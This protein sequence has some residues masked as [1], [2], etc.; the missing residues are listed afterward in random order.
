MKTCQKVNSLAVASLLA[1]TGI[2]PAADF[3][4]AGNSAALDLASAWTNGTAPGATDIAVWNSQ[5]SGANAVDVLGGNTSWAGIRILNPGATVQINPDGSTLT[6]GLAGIDLSHAAEDLVLSNNLALNQPQ[7]W[8]LASGRTLTLGG[9]VV[10]NAGGAIRF[11]LAD[12]TAN[13][14]VTN[15]PGALLLNGDIAF[16]TVN[17]TDFAAINGSGQIVAGNT[18]G[19][20]TANPS[21]NFNGTVAVVDF[22]TAA[23]AGL[24]LNKNSVL[25][26]IRINQ[27]NTL[28]PYWTINTGGKTLSINSL[29]ITTNVGAQPV[30]VN[31]NGPVRIYNTGSDELLL[32]QNNP[33][34]PLV[35]QSSAPITQQAG[36]A[37]VT[38]LGAGTVQIQSASAYTGGTLVYEGTLAIN[39][40]GTVGTAALNVYGG[41]FSGGT[42]STNTAPSTVYTNGIFGVAINTFGG[43][44]VQSSNLT[45][46]AGSHLQFAPVSGIALSPASPPLVITNPAAVLTTSNNVSID[47]LCSPSVGQFPLIKFANLAGAGFTG[48]T[49]TGLQPHVSAY[50]SNNLANSSI[51]LVVLANNDPL[52]W[53]TGNGTWDI[54]TTLD[55]QDATGAAATYQQSGIFADAVV[56][57]DT[58]S[59]A[60]PISITLNS[61]VAPAS[62]TFATSKNFTLTGTG[63]ITGPTAVTQSGTG[64]LTLAT[65]N[66]FTGGL[67]LNGGVTSFST[68]PNLGGAALN[69]SGGTLRYNGNTDD[70]S[71]RT[72]NFNSGGAIIDDGGSSIVFANPVGNGGVG[73]LTK[74]GSGSLTLNGTN[75][76]LGNTVV[77][78]GVLTLAGSAYLT[79]SAAIIVSNG[80]TWDVS[81]NSPVALQ[82]QVLAGNGTVN[83]G[84]KLGSGSTLSPATNGAIGTLTIN[85]GDLTVSGGTLALDVSSSTHDLIVVNGNLNLTGG[86]VQLN[87]INPLANRT[88]KL[89][90]YSGALLS[91]AG[92][93]ANLTLSGFSQNGQSATLSDANAGEIDLVVSSGGSQSLIWQGDGGNNNWDIGLS[94]VWTNSNGSASVFANADAVIFDNTSPNQTVNLQASVQPRSVTVNASVNYTFQDGSGTGTGKITGSTG[95]TKSG[96]GTLTLLTQDNNSGATLISGGTLQVGNGGTTGDI[97]IGNIT[98]NATLLF[99]QTDNRSVAGTITGTGSLLQQGSATLTLA[100]N[101]SYTGGTT[102]GSGILQVGNGDTTG[103][104]GSAPVTN[105]GTLLINRSGI[106]SLNNGISGSGSL[107]TTGPG[108]LTLGGNNTYQG[109]TYISNGIVKLGGAQALPSAVT[110]PGS[111]GALVINGST[112]TLDLNGF[113][114]TVNELSAASGIITNSALSGTNTFTV[115]DANATTFGGNI[116]ENP[117]GAKIA[118]VKQGSGS[119]DLTGAN[120]YSGGTFVGGG[121]LT[122]GPVGTIGATGSSLTLSNGTILALTSS[123]SSHASLANNIIIADNAVGTITADNLGD[124]ISGPIT[125]SASATNSITGSVSFGGVNLQQFQNFSGTVQVQSGGGI[126]FSATAGLNN[127]GNNA[128]F[129]LEGGSLY[130]RNN[131]TVSLGALTGS[132]SGSIT[133]PSVTGTGT[134]VIG[135][136]GINTAFPGSIQGANNL[137]KV[138]SGTLTLNGT[139]VQTTTLNGDGS[140][141]T[142]YSLGNLLTYTGTTTI[143]NGV[144]V[145]TAPAT[146]TNSP[147]ITLAATTAV[148]DIAN[149]GYVNGEV[150]ATNS[151]LEI[152]SGQALTGIGTI[153]GNLRADAG[154]TVNIGLP[155]GL[156]TVTTNVELAGT[157]NLALDPTNSPN[158]SELVAR[159]FVIDP[160]A[161]LVISN[162]GGAFSGGQTFQLFGQPVN[163]FASVTL[164]ALSS[165]LAWTNKLA[166][167][168]SIAVLGS[169]VNTNAVSLVNTLAGNSLTLTWPPDHTGWHLQVQT[170]A[171]GT[172]LGTNWVDWAG[173]TA[174][175]Q[176]SITVNPANGA[177]FFRLTYP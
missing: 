28:N 84:V 173:S 113:M 64:T 49:L 123:G 146:L 101:D 127:G 160:T 15:P 11:E 61:P 20:Y 38:K 6:N 12:S 126:R 78:A 14:L 29:L 103:T 32:F 117:A 26:G 172:G 2:S 136:K 23:T 114:A 68:L 46:R 91:G 98:N 34:A 13:V 83:G 138:G 144:L 52:K 162:A 80:A 110:T 170:N 97:G 79:N 159:S 95:L 4:R 105:N 59:G 21:G 19:N 25:D 154:S 40:G 107:I 7:Y 152:I 24:T 70:I 115:G 55:W 174:T 30:Y 43:Q 120:N 89:I 71:T 88:Y 99:E 9:S 33:A 75:T 108:T 158:S 66:S 139:T 118:L 77:G 129:D 76:Y 131:G 18:L 17:D 151:L 124:T 85:N 47:I 150:L 39:G 142:N 1:L 121:T 157:V 156:L 122:V 8:S 128:V 63:G 60:S 62:V 149:G 31:G 10:K 169:T 165:P 148:L 56:F 133:A 112:S 57:E 163:G 166:V 73:G 72:I 102:I 48:F 171:P 69:F 177:V 135:A 155:T 3:F 132:A 140:T 94:A 90:Q 167:D 153:R 145:L 125:G 41:E 104:L 86:A 81:Q 116:L 37:V 45:L 58:V 164:P 65:T 147:V 22:N 16:G 143:S 51:D 100:A 96:T 54:G 27:P 35:F 87:A 130:V 50:L 109:S 137:I 161:V 5:V 141:T 92:S 67:N 176:A 44:F 53:A 82:N 119:L 74:T 106:Y 42:G 168:G 111:T 175:N 134:F 93:S 36:A